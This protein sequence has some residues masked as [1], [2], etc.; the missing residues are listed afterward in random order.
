MESCWSWCCAA[1]IRYSPPPGAKCRFYPSCSVRAEVIAARSRSKGLACDGASALHPIIGRCDR[2]VPHAPALPHILRP[3]HGTQPYP[4][5]HLCVSGCFLWSA[6]RRARP[7]LCRPSAAAEPRHADACRAVPLLAP[8]H[9]HASCSGAA[10]RLRSGPTAMSPTVETLGVS[11]PVALTEHR[12]T[13]T[14]TSLLLR[15][16]PK[17]N[18]SRRG[19]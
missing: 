13:E 3:R 16:E 12:D 10:K 15:K 11:H 6:G 19:L 17:P 4:V 5:R 2:A 7:P 8:L 1:T 18:L 9:G 14:R